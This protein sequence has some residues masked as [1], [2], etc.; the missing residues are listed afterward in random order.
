[1]LLLAVIFMITTLFRPLGTLW[2]CSAC[3]CSNTEQIDGLWL[4]QG[5]YPYSYRKIKA[6][7]GSQRS[8]VIGGPVLSLAYWEF[9]KYKSFLYINSYRELLIGKR[10]VEA[11]RE[12]GKK[13]QK[14]TDETCKTTLQAPT[15]AWTVGGTGDIAK[16]F[17]S[18][19]KYHSFSAAEKLWGICNI[20]AV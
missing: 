11:Y 5:P 4:F 12:L 6:N 1:M 19:N 18:R 13:P 14:F 8:R 15:N 10:N 3:Q 7:T 16:S 17:K 9:S 2:P 20:P